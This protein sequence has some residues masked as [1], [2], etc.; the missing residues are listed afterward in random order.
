MTVDNTG[1]PGDEAVAAVTLQGGDGLVLPVAITQ[2]SDRPVT[3][4][5]AVRPSGQVQPDSPERGGEE[6]RIMGEID[7]TVAAALK[8]YL[9]QLRFAPVRNQ[10][11]QAIATNARITV[12]ISQVP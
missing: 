3:A 8:N 4:Q 6:I 5:I 1:R 2:W 7:S 9:A 11:G 12:Q 10:Q